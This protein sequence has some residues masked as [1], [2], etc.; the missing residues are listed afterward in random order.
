MRIRPVAS[1]QNYV[2]VALILTAVRLVNVRM[3]IQGILGRFAFQLNP[4]D[5]TFTKTPP[6]P[7]VALPALS[8]CGRSSG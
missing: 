2:S 4:P 5:L 7:L 1:Q 3:A 8:G 6:V